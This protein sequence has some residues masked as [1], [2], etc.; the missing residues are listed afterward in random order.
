LKEHRDRLFTTHDPN[1]AARAADRAYLLR[2]GARLAEG[3]VEA[4][5][6]HVQLEALYQT[7]VELVTDRDSGRSA[8]LP[9]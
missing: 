2:D 3:T 6:G 9:A 4:V 1:H 5:L 8:F 7:P